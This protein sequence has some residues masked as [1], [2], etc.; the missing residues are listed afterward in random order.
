[1][2]RL[3]GLLSF[4]G[5]QLIKKLIFMF[6]SIAILFFLLFTVS[7][8]QAETYFKDSN[9]EL[10]IREKA[11]ISNGE[12]KN[13]DLANI[14]HLD[15]SGMGIRN[16]EGIEAL[17]D[18]V[19]LNLEDNR[20]ECLLPLRNLRR[21]KEL[22]LRNNQ[23]S[24]LD[25]INFRA[26]QSINLRE[27]DLR[28]NISINTDNQ[29]TGLKNISLI[30]TLTSLEKL[31][32]RDNSISDISSLRHLKK[33]KHINLR[34]NNIEDISYLKYMPDLQYI[35]LRQN[36]INEINALSELYDLEYL[37]LRDNKIIDL[38][39][40]AG[41]KNL[42]ILNLRGNN[43]SNISPLKE[44]YALKSLNLR[45]I[46]IA[47]QIVHLSGLHQL[48]AL[49]LRNTMI[50]DISI[51][52]NLVFLRELNL[53][54]NREIR[55][56][57]PLSNLIMLE[58][59]N[60]R[61][62]PVYQDT[63]IFEN[64]LQLRDLN[65]LNCG[66][67]DT[68]IFIRLTEIGALQGDVRPNYLLFSLGPPS[69]S[70]GAGWYTE[71]I[72][73]ALNTEHDDTLILYTLD[74]SEPSIE[75][76]DNNVNSYLIAYYYPE[77]NYD[78]ELVERQNTTFIY[79]GPVL[80]S[81]RS[82][83]DNDISN[84]M[85]TWKDSAP[86]IWR[87]PQQKIFKGHIVRAR[88]YSPNG[89]SPVITK[90]FFFSKEKHNRYSLPVLSI[91]ANTR[92]LMDF[93]EGIYVPGMECNE[94]GRSNPL[95]ANYFKRGIEIPVHA[96]LFDTDGT[97][98]MAQN[99]G[100]RIHGNFG[101]LHPLKAFRLYARNHYDPEDLFREINLSSGL[102][103]EN[104]PL[105]IHKRLIFRQGGSVFDIIKDAGIH[106]ILSPLNIELQRSRPIVHFINGEYWGLLNIRDRQDSH[107]LALKYG[108]NRDNLIIIDSPYGIGSADMLRHGKT[109]DITLY[110][111][112][113]SFIT[114]TDMATDENYRHLKTLLNIKS[115]I[116]YNIAFIYWNNIDWFGANH[117]RYWRVREP[118]N[119]EYLDGRW[120]M[121]VWDFDD[122]T[123]G[124]PIFDFL[125][126]FIHPKGKGRGRWVA[127]DPSKTSMLLNLLE[128]ENFK[129][130]FIN[131]FADLLN[132]AFT[133]KRIT[134]IITRMYRSI[135]RE[136]QEHQQRWNHSAINQ[137]VADIVEY[138]L[139]R[140]FYQRQHIMNH[141]DISGEIQVT[142]N[143]NN[144]EYGHIKLNTININSD[145]PG[146]YG[147]P[148]PWQGTYFIDVPISLKAIPNPGHKFV[149]WLEIDEISE[150]I[151]L[152]LKHD[153]SL[154]AIFEKYP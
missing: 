13:S 69:F 74:G 109:E 100:M 124:G 148:Y 34:E 92:D 81:D 95:N 42:N 111:D 19:V 10:I 98:L 4:K 25:S 58:S 67:T 65:V 3:V 110:N 154:T 75:N 20:I 112:L 116:D 152:G 130:L 53:H 118:E 145:T 63:Q 31:D 113:Y 37:N 52:E 61:Y 44:L 76:V 21:L 72:Q 151:S 57:G 66:I 30:G 82:T 12:L 78:C 114:E 73:L 139:E 11:G 41:L 56:T 107:Y 121:M 140:P 28:H 88:T 86:F 83:E 99:A 9:L 50:N 45:D 27:L 142:L 105:N 102:F 40:I 33:L 18:L 87:Q 60:L 26:L 70:H 59:L 68:D 104:K 6:F 146:I 5:K 55:D 144:Y 136:L 143:V 84:I 149:R 106:N 126:N 153:I 138:S 1:M 38:G 51:L 23:I 48:E 39:P 85:T 125:S 91:S 29:K 135:A 93:D 17:R 128:N 22:N 150:N 77:R 35:N 137:R 101:R 131:R 127:G 15:A 14:T 46:H 115:Y 122:S 64:M 71:P 96:E 119:D 90:S 147:I 16:L 32:L 117:F 79:E 89:K 43:L 94:R 103:Y 120:R 97:L 36:R 8:Y 132:T 62:V 134:D 54:S 123:A 7:H 2:I 141:F 49:N 108:T 24:D 133:E 80:L 129:I 47:D